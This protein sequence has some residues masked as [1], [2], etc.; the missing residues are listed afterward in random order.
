LTLLSLPNLD[1][2]PE[3][4]LI[5][6]PIKLEHEPS[7]LESHIPLIRNECEP[8]HFDLDPTLE[9]YPILEP[10]FDLKQFHES[11]LVLKL[12]T[13]EPKSI[14]LSNHIPLLE[15]GVEQYNSEIVNQHWSCNKDECHDR[16]LYDP[17]QF[18][19]YNNVNGLEVEGE[20][21]RTPNSMDWVATLTPIRP[22]P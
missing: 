18:G 10:R 22:P 4:T 15:Q 14:I 20:F 12:F 21:L 9:S 2:L 6:V 11:L 7:I 13:L 17:I 3:P 8:Q 5:L 1:H 16:I 19:G